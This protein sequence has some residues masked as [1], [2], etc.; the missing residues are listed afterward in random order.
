M[1][2]ALE[3]EG[4]T[5]I[6]GVPGEENIVLLDAI[7]RSSIRFIVTRHEQT[8][9]FMAATHGRL[10]GKSGVCL[11][12]L[13]PGAT[14]LVTGAAYALL[15]GMPMLMITG[16]KPILQSKQAG[17]QLIDV[18]AMMHPLTKFS[19]QIVDAGTI[20]SLVR[21]A[22]RI[23]EGERA[24][25]VHLEL[26][27]DIAAQKTSRT[28]LITRSDVRAPVAPDVAIEEAV[29]RIVQAKYPLLMF[30]AGSNRPGLHA[31]LASFVHQVRIPF[32]NTQ[33]GKGSVSC[34]SDL[35]I[36][37]AAL[38]EHDYLHDVI[39]CADLI[40]AIGYDTVE[41]PPFIMHGGRPQIV[42]IDCH[43]AD[44]SEVYAPHLEIIGH[45][46][47]SVARIGQ[48]IARRYAE[49]AP[50]FDA[51]LSLRSKVHAHVAE[52]AEDPR[53]PVVP[54]R[55]V[56][57]VRRVMPENGM[58][59]L[60][61]G[62]YKLWFARN[63]RAQ[64][65]N[66]LLL[67]NTLATMGAGLASAM[68]C[69]ML[70]PKRR[71][72]AVCGDGGF[73]MNSQDLETAVRRKLNLVVLIV[74]DHAYGMIRWKQASMGL[75]DFGLS[76]NNPDFVKYAQAYGASG[77]RVTRTE[78]LAKVLENAFAKGSVHVVVVPVDY[79][80]NQR[81][82][83]DELKHHTPLTLPAQPRKSPC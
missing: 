56:H 11:S 82:L 30:G 76:F 24:G 69:A 13:G 36:G 16:Q 57:E 68:T 41:K 83:V 44:I 10:T 70:Y 29:E 37:T 55:L 26:P 78:D 32:F 47:D 59:T 60:D 79:S 53:F 28:A 6:F 19:E 48:R 40:V 25:P 51:V 20:P 49:S 8:A 52:R 62:M 35:Y 81:V 27:E 43:P 75:P 80:E 67:D 45:I 50:S 73:M 42:H 14:N 17:F 46:P 15:G 66:T 72:M 9:A 63:Y 7:R 5:E 74:E 2:R 64:M 71:V 33:M 77:T 54:Q 31:A 1:V 39:A 3:H 18:I 12:T 4:V 23:A 22:F 21:K 61:N 65:A 58:V 38:S 34:N